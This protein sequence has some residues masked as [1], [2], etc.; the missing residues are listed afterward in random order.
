MTNEQ[1]LTCAINIGEQLLING[2]EISRVEDTISRICSAYGVRQSHIFSIAS[3]IIVSLETSD[4]EWITQTR[5]ILN[6]GTNMYKLDR[7]NNLS[8]K[9]CS[10]TSAP[11]GDRR[12]IRCNC[13]EQRIS[14][15]SSDCRLCDGGGGLYCFFR[16]H[17]EGRICRRICRRTA[18]TDLVRPAVY[19]DETD[20]LQYHL[21]HPVG[22]FMYLCLFCRSWPAF[23]YDYDR[24]YH[25]AD[26]GGAVDKL[27]P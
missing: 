6:Y 7:L 25:A 17:T 10:G 15:G 3:C 21:F 23:G 27:V 14:T 22:A 19:E 26:T 1:I 12:G 8:R 9:I 4:G 16:G 5:R 24:Q 18:E 11:A 13:K 20:I 2:A